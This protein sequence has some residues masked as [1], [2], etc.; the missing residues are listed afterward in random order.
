M[1]LM[2]LIT[3][4]YF[5]CLTALILTK[6][7]LDACEQ[8]WVSKLAPYTFD[9][10]HIAGTKNV[11]ADTLSRDPFARPVSHRLITEQY[12]HLLTE[13]ENVDYDGIQDTFRLKALC[14]QA[15]EPECSEVTGMGHLGVGTAAPLGR[16]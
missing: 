6:P 2:R 4:K 11:V 14:Q 1:T 5:N 16:S 15:G 8:R 13:S 7:K 10:K 12:H 9:L 3:I